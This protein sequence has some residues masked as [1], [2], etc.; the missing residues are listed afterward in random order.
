M[1]TKNDKLFSEEAIDVIESGT[2]VIDSK[3]CSHKLRILLVEDNLM[4]VKAAQILF[5]IEGCQVDHAKDG[6]E[7]VEMAIKNHYDGIYMDIGLPIINGIEACKIIREHEIKNHLVQVPIIAVTGNYN[8]E[9]TKEYIK[10][11]MQ[12]VIAK[13]LTKEKAQHFLSF[14]K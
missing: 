10:A 7:A 6:R 8:P 9:E 2:D 1:G 5:Q 13:P 3:S 11:G 14:C 12:E 4:A